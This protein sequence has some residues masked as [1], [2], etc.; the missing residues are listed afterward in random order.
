M[1]K[2]I[3][4]GFILFLLTPFLASTALTASEDALVTRDHFVTHVSTVPANSGSPVG[5]FVRQ[6]VLA[7]KLGRKAPVVLFVHGAT[8]PGV[9][10]YDLEY[11]D[12]NWMA[13]LARAGFNAY[14]MD[15]TGYGGSP[16]PMMDD[17]CNVDP[18]QQD[19]IKG[20][21]LKAACEP[22]YPYQMNTIRDDWAE[23]NTVVDHLRKVNRVKRINMIGW[24]AGG[25]RVGGYIAQHPE[26][27]ERAMLY[28]PS[29][30]IEGPVPDKPAAG[31]PMSLQTREDFEKK[32]WDPDVRCQGQVE[33]GVRD[34][35][36]TEIMK[37]DKVGS[38]WGPEGIGVMRGRIATR[39]GWTKELTSKVVTPTLIVVGEYDRLKERRVVYDQI[40]SKEK[41]FINVACASHFMVWEKQRH[42]LHAT[43]LEWFTRG[44]VQKVKSGEFRVEE[45]GT[46]KSVGGAVK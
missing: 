45:D 26:K 40:S 7:S 13:H 33:P 14:T 17:P 19:I 35:V 22:N 23:I 6:K 1:K 39:F 3:I 16:K 11:K 25:P 12:Y 29:P 38:T 41:V 30:P 18:K 42:V 2:I 32:R 15:L 44:R 20:R 24:S 4:M 43:S 34:A 8:V 9:P 21:P 31:A 27:I 46:Y 28:A 5:I 36:W 37:W 10:D